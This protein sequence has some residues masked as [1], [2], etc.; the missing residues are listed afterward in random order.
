LCL[1]RVVVKFKYMS[2]TATVEND[3][4]RLP[5]GMHIPDGTQVVIETVERA[6][7]SSSDSLARCL[8]EYA[9]IADDLPSDLAANLDHYL[10]GHPKRQ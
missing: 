1:L 8:A 9:G 4:I 3:I 10:H 2:I 5:E 7:D 6:A